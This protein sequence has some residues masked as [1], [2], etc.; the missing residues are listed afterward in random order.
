MNPERHYLEINRQSWNSRTEA[1][2]QSEFYNQTGFMAGESSLNSIE[3]ELLGDVTGKRILHLQ[4]HLT[5]LLF[6]IL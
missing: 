1:H 5:I 6:H 2:L 4:C 3:L